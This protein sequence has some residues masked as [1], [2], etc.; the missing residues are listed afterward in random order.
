MKTETQQLEPILTLSI[1]QYEDIH[2]FLQKM[3]KEIGTASPDDLLESN[4][5]L[6]YLQSQATEADQ[7]LLPQLSKHSVH[8]ETS[9]Q[10]IDKREQIL[11]E[12]LLLN[13]GITKKALGV[14]SLITHEMEKL[15]NG[16]SALSG[17]RRQQNNQGRLVNKTS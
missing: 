16:I 13:E 8:T 1:R 11:K 7:V 3:D 12:I 6:A 10:L 15:R 4:L 2:D 14:N 9:Q 17:Y 5:S